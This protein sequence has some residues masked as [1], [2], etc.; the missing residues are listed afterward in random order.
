MN[1]G[2]YMNLFN[3]GISFVLAS[4]ANEIMN[5]ESFP[6]AEC[7]CCKPILEST[8]NYILLSSLLWL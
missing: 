5:E 8:E 3:K 2:S 4:F 6:V 7:N 1:W